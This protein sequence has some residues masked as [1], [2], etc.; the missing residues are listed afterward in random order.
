MTYQD[1]NDLFNLMQQVLENELTEAV[2]AVSK[3]EEPALESP[4][5]LICSVSCHSQTVKVDDTPLT[6][7]PPVAKAGESIEKTF[8]QEIIEIAA[9]VLKIPLDK[10]DSKENMA[11]YGVD[12]IIVTEIMRRIS[13]IVDLPIAPTL[14]FE[15]RHLEELAEILWKRYQKRIVERY[16]DNTPVPESQTTPVAETAI[17][18]D[19]EV[20]E[21]LKKYQHLNNNTPVTPEHPEQQTPFLVQAETS[22]SSD[23]EP[24]A[25]IAMEGM[26]AESSNLEEFAKHLRHGDD[27]IREIP[28]SRW[29]W[30]KVY[31]DPQQ[32]E[33]TR[34][35]FGGFIPEIDKFDPLFFG[36][37]PKEA[38]L[39]DPQHRLFIQ[40][41]WKLIESAGY[42][43]RSFSDK[44]IGL[45]LGINLQDY[46]HL[47]DRA[48]GMEA[49]HLTSLGHMFC[50]NRLSFLLN[51]H[52]PSQV[53]DTACSSSLVALH[54][55][56]LSIQHEGCEMA[57]AGGANLMISPDMHIMYSKVGMICEDGRCKTFSKQANGYVR[58]DGIGAVL[59]K[60]LSQAEADGDTILA[61]I[62]G[63]AE[64]HGGLSTSLTAPNP[65]AQAKLIVEAQQ[66]ANIDPRT[67]SYIECHGTGTSLGD[68]IEINGLK[69]AFAERFEQTAQQITPASCALGSVK[70]NIGHAETAAG[71]AGV[72]KVLLSLQDQYL[73]PTLHCAEVNPLIELNDSPFYLLQ[74]GRVWQRPIVDGKEY[75]RRAGISSFGAGGS[76]AHVVIEEYQAPARPDIPHNSPML[77]VLSAKNEARLQEIVKNLY[78]FLNEDK[79]ADLA[80]ADIAYT[81]QLGREAMEE[82]L[83]FFV[84]SKVELFTKLDALING[85]T[86]TDV[87]RGNSKQ[88]KDSRSALEQQA[89]QIEVTNH[90]L[91][92]LASLWAK[93]A[94]FDWQA[95]WTEQKPQRVKLP[96]YPFA[97]QRY[98]I[99]E[100][101][102]SRHIKTIVAQQTA[103]LHPLL[104]QNTSLLSE[105]R[106]TSNFTGNEFFL[107]DHV[108]VGNKMLPGVAYLEMAV[109]AVQQSMAIDR[110]NSSVIQL[111]NVVW[112]RPYIFDEHAKPLHIGLYPQSDTQINYSIYSCAEDEEKL[113]HSQGLIVL[114]QAINPTS[115]NLTALQQRLHRHLDGSAC[116][117][118]F[119]ALAMDYGAGHQGL[120]S[121]YF[122]TDDNTQPQVLAKLS[123]PASVADT[124]NQYTAHPSLLDSALQACVGLLF[125]TEVSAERSAKASLPFALDNLQLLAPCQTTMWAWIRYAEGGNN[126]KVQKLNIE[127]CDAQ[128]QVCVRLQGFSSRVVD[129]TSS[130]DT[131]Q[132]T[133]LLLSQPL[134]QV[135]DLHQSQ[136]PATFVKHWV[137]LCNLPSINSTQITEQLHNSHCQHLQI[138]ADNIA[139][140]YQTIVLT[141]FDAIQNLLKNKLQGNV[142]IQVVIANQDEARLVAGL[143]GLFK[144]VQREHATIFGQVIS[145]EAN[146]NTQSLLNK[147]H[148]NSLALDDRSIRYRAGQREIVI[149]Q[150]VP[151]T[152]E[153]YPVWKNNGVY[154]ITG[155]T[156]G[157]GRLFVEEIVKNTQDAVIIL[158]GRSS[159]TLQQQTQLEQLQ[160][161]GARIEYRRVD[162][163]VAEQ[164]DSLIATIVQNF[165]HLDGILHTAGVLQDNFIINKTAAEFAT[166]F[167]PKVAGTLHLDKAT[168]HLDMDFFVLFSSIAGGLGSAGQSDYAAANA[169]MD[170]FADYR[171]AQVRAKQRHGHTV[172]ILWSLWQDGGM[173]MDAASQASMTANIGL[174]PLQTTTAMHAFYQILMQGLS[175]VLVLEGQVARIKTQLLQRSERKTP[176]NTTTVAR[177]DNDALTRKIEQVLLQ[178]VVDLM[179]F[180]LADVDVSSELSEYGF[181]SISFTEFA[182]KLNK[183]LGLQLTPTSFFEYPTIAEF[184]QYLASNF[185]AELSVLLGLTATTAV[186]QTQET[187]QEDQPISFTAT[188]NNRFISPAV[189]TNV[190]TAATTQTQTISDEPIAIVGMSGCFPMAEDLQAFWQNLQAGKDCITEI[191]KDRWNWQALYGDPNK[192]RDKTNIKW[193]GFIDGVAEFDAQFFGISPREAEL[194][195]PQQRLLMQYVWAAIED[196]GYAPL[197]LSGS[198]TGLFI[199]TASSGYGEL[200]AKH[201]I[202]IDSYSATGTVGS[203]GPNR[204]SYFLNIHGPSEPIETACSSSLVAIHKA[205]LAIKHGDCEQAIVGG[206]NLIL[207]PETHISFNKAGMLCEDGRC[208]TFAKQANGYV[209]GEGVGMLFLKKLSDAE[210]AGDSIYAV[211]RGSSQNHGGRANSLTA[212]NPKAQA[213]C[214]ITAYKRA[215]IDP[216]TVSY[217][218]A[219]GTGTEL[220]DPIEINAL[221]NAFKDL[222]QA[223]GSSEVTQAHCGLSSVKTHIGHLEL[224]AGVAGVIRVILQMK[225]QTLVKGLH[226]AEVNPY[227]QLQDSPFYLV[228][229]NRP[230]LPLT[231][232]Q[233]H[234]VPRRAGVSSF[235]FGG[236]NAHVVLEEY[237][238]KQPATPT[239]N[240]EHIIVLSAKTPEGLHEIAVRL[241]AFIQMQTENTATQSA[242]TDAK[243][244]LPQSAALLGEL[245]QQWIAE[246]LA[247][248]VQDIGL[249]DDLL[250]CGLDTVQKSQLFSRLQQ[251]YAIEI[252]AQHF[253][254]Y[255]SI[256]EMIAGL[257]TPAQTAQTSTLNL[258]DL[259]YT[260][261]VGR[262][263]MEERLGFVVNSLAELTEKLTAFVHNNRAT[264]IYLGN[265]RDHK[266]I[267]ASF[268]SDDDFQDV[269]GKWI[270]R[271]KFT[272]LLD[273]WVKGLV[274]DWQKLY[275]VNAAYA[276]RPRRISLP[277]Y[278]FAKERYWIE[279]PLN[280]VTPIVSVP[281]SQP[282]PVVLA[283]P[284]VENVVTQDIPL[285]VK[286]RQF[287][288]DLLAS[289]LKLPAQRIK[290]N[291]ALETYGIDSMMVIELTNKLE[292]TFGSLSKTLFFEY[293]TLNELAD[294]F[295]QAHREQLENLFQTTSIAPVSAPLPLNNVVIEAKPEPEPVPTSTTVTQNAPLNIAIV[296]LS[297]RY[298]QADNLAQYWQ[299]LSEGKDCITEI[300]KER[301]DWQAYYSE[302]RREQ[303]KHFSKWGGFIRDVD[304][305][306][307]LFF[308]IS[309]REAET[310]DPQERL[311]LEHVW[312][313]LE[314]A[315]Y[316][317]EALQHLPNRTEQ[318]LAAQI[319]V[320]VGVMYSEYQLFAAQASLLGET[321]VASGSYA[322]IANRVSYLLNL[323]GPSMTLDTMCSSSLTA[324][325]LAC[326]DLRQGRT[327]M[328]FAGGVNVSVHPNK[329][330]MLSLGQFISTRGHC[331]SFGEGGDGYIPGEGVG[332]AVLKRLE[333]A[334]RDG[335]HIYGVIKGSA[336]NHGGKTNG[337]SVPNPKAQQ[338]VIS[339]ALKQAQVDPRTISYIEAHGTGTKLGDPIEITGLTKAFQKYT[340]DKQYCWLG[341]A[342]SNIGHCESA[343]GIAGVTKVLL[344]MQYEKI[345][346]SLHSQVLN[347]F[348][349]FN[350]TP[351]IVNQEL[352]PWQRPEHNGKTLPRI[353]GISSFGAGG[354]NAH[355]IIEEYSKPHSALTNSITNQPYA[356]LLSAKT[357]DQLLGLVRQLI[358]YTQGQISDNALINIAYTLQ[359]GRQ[360]MN[361]RLG[362]IVTSV[363]ELREKL[364]QFLQK[365]FV[366]NPDAGVYYARIK[367]DSEEPHI[368]HLDELLTQRQ[369][370]ELLSYWLQDVAIDWRKLYVNTALPQRISL[371]T[372]PFAKE[373]YWL[374]VQ[375]NTTPKADDFFLH[376]LIHKNSS[377]ADT[378]RFSTRFTAQEFFLR[379]HK[380]QGHAI[381]PAVAYL[382][383]ARAAVQH[384][385]HLQLPCR[386]KNI[387]WARPLAVDEPK[388]VHIS[389]TETAHQSLSYQI[390]GEDNGQVV[391]SQGSI[392]TQPLDVTQLANLN[393]SVLQAR[394]NQCLLTAEQC[395]T[396]FS[397]MGLDYGI[398][399]RALVAVYG[400]TT[401]NH[402]ELLAQL[403]MPAEVRAFSDLILHPSMLDSALQ[404]AIGFSL[405]SSAT[406][407]ALPFALDSVEVYQP[408]T[409]KMW[410]WLR[411]SDNKRQKLAIDLCDDQGVLC[412]RLIG[413][414]LRLLN[415]TESPDKTIDSLSLAPV[416]QASPAVS[417]TTPNY[418]AHYV[419]FCGTETNMALPS[420]ICSRL[421]STATELAQRFQD[422]ALTL[423]D[424]IKQVLSQKHTGQVLFQV[425]INPETADLP[426]LL[427]A[428]LAGLLKTARQENPQF[429]TQL[430]LLDAPIAQ[431]A[432]ATCLQENAQCPNDVLISYQAQQRQIAVWQSL[433]L[434]NSVQIPW[435]EHGVYLIT[436]G[437]GGLGF[438]FAQEIAQQCQQVTL[439]LTGRSSINAEIQHKLSALTALN[440]TKA[441]YHAIDV[442]NQTAVFGLMQD[443]TKEYGGLNAI[444]HC[445]GVTRDGFILKKT[446]TDWQQVFA[447]KV[448]GL[449][450]LDL[451][452]RSQ[453]LDFFIL[454][455]SVAGA[456]GNV[457][458]AD[459]ATA[460]AF[461]D[462]YAVYRNDL[463][464][465]VLSTDTRPKGLTLSINWPLWQDGGMDIAPEL[466]T[467]MR[468]SVG[469]I[470]LTTATALRHFYQSL[471]AGLSQV[472][473]VE[474]EVERLK[475]KLLTQTAESEPQAETS[476][477]THQE[478]LRDKLD[479]Y[480]KGL[481]SE[482][483]KI[484]LHRI[485]TGVALEKYGMDSVSVMTLTNELEQLF[486]SLPKTLLFEYS[487]IDA[488]SRYFLT[489]HADKLP[490]AWR[491][492]SIEP[493]T[494][495]PVVQADTV[496]Q[497][498]I[499]NTDIAIIGLAGRY[500]QAET[501]AEFWQN[502][503]E[504]K[505]NIRE[506]PASRWQYRDYFSEDK[507]Q[508]GKS[509]CKWG[510]FLD[511]VDE[512]DPLFFNIS[513][514]EAKIMDPME[515]LFLETVW[516]LL[517]SA[518]YLGDSLAKYA[519]DVA[520]YVGAM[521][522]QYQQ[523]AEHDRIAP[524]SSF[525]AIANRVS[526]F[527]N[528]QGASVAID[529]M[530]SSAMVALHLACDSLL[531]QECKLAIVGGVNLSLHPSKYIGLSSAQLLGSHANSTS[532][533]EGDGYIPA[534]GVGAVLLKPLASAIQDNDTILAVI[535]STAINHNGQA[536][537]YAVPNPNAQGQLMTDNF[538]KANIDPRSISY[539]EAAANG[540]LLGD[541]IE[542]KALHNVFN[543]TNTAQN[544]CALGSVKA[545][546]GHAEAASGMAQLS[547]VVLQLQHQQIVPLIKAEPLNPRLDFSHSPF[548]LPRQV[549]TWQ[550][551]VVTLEDGSTR[552]LPRRAVLNS[553]G[554]GGTNVHV[555]IEEYTAP[556]LPQSETAPPYLILL[557]AKNV[558]QLRTVIQRLISF[559]QNHA[560]LSLANLAYT[561]QC[562]R[563]ALDCRLA[564]VVENKTQLLSQLQSAQRF[565]TFSNTDTLFFADIHQDHS[566]I[567]QSVKGTAGQ[568]LLQQ[569]LA[570]KNLA[571]LGFY[572]VHGVTID[573]QTLHHGSAVQRIVLPTYPFVKQRY[574]LN[575]TS[576]T[577]EN[578]VFNSQLSLKDNM[579][580][581]L[582]S[583]VANALNI[584]TSSI[585][586][587][588]D[589]R[590]YGMNSL[591]GMNL[592]RGFAEQ[593]AVATSARDL[594]NH[595]SIAQ[596][597]EYFAALNPE[598]VSDL[599]VSTTTNVESV[600]IPL[601]EGQKGL[602]LLHKFAPEMSAYN[603]PIA[604]ESNT[605]LNLQALKQACTWLMTQHSLLRAVIDE[606]N[607]NVPYQ[608]ILPD[609]SLSLT[610][611]L[612]EHLNETELFNAVKQQSKAVFQ[613]NSG[614]LFRVDVFYR[615]NQ[616]AIVLLTVHHLIFDGRSA[617]L[618]L[619]QL[620]SLYASYSQQKTPRIT[621]PQASYHDF[622]TWEHAL[623][624]STTGQQHE[625]YWQTQLAGELPVCLFP[626]DYARPTQQS[627]TGRRYEIT[628]NATLSAQLKTLAYKQAVQLSSV[629]L[630]AFNVLFYRYTGQTDILMGMP[631]QGRPEA[632]FDDVIG[633]FINVIVIR[634]QLSAEQTFAELLNTVQFTVADGLDHAAYPLPRLI[635]LLKIARDPAVAPL[636]QM[637]YAYQN[638]ATT[639]AESSSEQDWQLLTDI[640]QEGAD[641]FALEV[642]ENNDRFVIS[643]DYNTD[644]FAETTIQRLMQHYLALLQAVSDAPDLAISH[645]D[646]LPSSERTQ[647]L[648]HWSG[649]QQ[650]ITHNIACI[651]DL[652]IKQA[653]KTPEQIALIL[654]K[655]QLSYR[656]LDQLSNQLAHALQKQGIVSGDLVGV[657]MKPSLATVVS[658]LAIFKLGAVYVP[659][660]VQL[661]K[662]RRQYIIEDS[663]IK[664]L[665]T[666]KALPEKQL[667]CQQWVI[668]KQ[669]QNLAGYKTR[670]KSH[671]QAEQLAYIIYTSGST[672]KPKG[673][674]ITH[675]AIAGH[676]QTMQNIYQLTEKDRVLQFASFAVD[677]S[678]EQL[679]PSLISGATVVLR[680]KALWSVQ[681]F[682]QHLFNYQLSII[683]IPPAYL[684]EW[685]L[686]LTK[687]TDIA[688]PHRLR[689][690]ITGGDV[691]TTH[692]V[693]LWRNSAMR[694][695]AL[696]NAY[697]PTETTIT[698]TLLNLAT[699]NTTSQNISIGRPLPNECVYILD[700]LGQAVPTGVL[701]ELHIG[702]AGLA[703][704]YLHRLDLTQ[705]KFIASPFDTKSKLYKTGDLA[706]W[707][708]DGTIEFL[709]RVDY[710]VKVR[711]FRIECGEIENV[712]LT[713]T[714]VKNALVL[715][716]TEQNNTQLRAYLVP[717]HNKD[718]DLQVLKHTLQQTLPSYMLPSAFVI[719]DKIPLTAT[720]KVD[721]QFLLNQAVDSV[722]NAH[723]VAPMTD[724]EQQ[725]A[726]IWQQLLNVPRI[727][728]FDNFFDL[729]GHSLLAVRL[730]AEITHHF[731]KELALSDLFKNPTIAGLAD[732]LTQK[733][734]DDSPLVVLQSQ[735]QKA[736]LFLIHA[737]T[738]QVLC[739][740]ELVNA[741]GDLQPCYGLEAKPIQ[742]HHIES[743]AANYITHIKRVQTSGAYYLAGWS[744]G[745]VIAYEMAR[746]LKNAGE[747]VALLALID[748]Y[749][750][751][752]L[753]AI[754]QDALEQY[755]QDNLLFMQFAQTLGLA[756]NTSNS[757]FD[758]QARLTELGQQLGDT[759]DT[760]LNKLNHLFTVY[761]THNEAMNQYQPQTYTGRVTLFT[762]HKQFE[763]NHQGIDNWSTL[764]GGNIQII[765]IT[766]DHYSL[767]QNENVQVLAT[768]LKKHLP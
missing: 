657:C 559:I 83:A 753:H 172:S 417:T 350:A 496:K 757:D 321:R 521:Y 124:F 604:I 451:A 541:A 30:Q 503:V 384:S 184:A 530:C 109:T 54:R 562:G 728:I 630:A 6:T 120:N 393:L 667:N 737:A 476:P 402:H 209:R 490:K 71:I 55:A 222:Y 126:S 277:T 299:N 554:A 707:L 568:T 698:S 435:R 627:F 162:V 247:V 741:L 705:E 531:K 181:D 175:H 186:E 742:Q 622:V 244:R 752:Q 310:M 498:V 64:N 464:T 7:K 234:A 747:N 607:N 526:Y 644:L 766:G 72:I 481:L 590:A 397:A 149:W 166:V 304:K 519:K 602:W 546:M 388:T 103:V 332:V 499:N 572:W 91:P 456:M 489:H 69:M 87:Y 678:L 571:Q 423:F 308:N 70:S 675:G 104:Q 655:Q 680:D 76:N 706:R 447:P 272:R 311:F 624:N 427:Y 176:S 117:A 291:E 688:I 259:A 514:E 232:Q 220:G 187:V 27:C 609:C 756:N 749:T 689:L 111:K 262:S 228:Q 56:I 194:M 535:K 266:A 645:Y 440:N 382:E 288:I 81:L 185:N 356:I 85:R 245:L 566:A 665:L 279:R 709:G 735:G 3:Q 466:K 378:Q 342:K 290:A 38:E 248:N 529:T 414:S 534:E 82:R 614:A 196:A 387:V 35:K 712:L 121:L 198:K 619:Q 608:F 1:E 714:N 673:V 390:Y 660:D 537:G 525:S 593:F 631:T 725:L 379:D 611:H 216:R 206:L 183:Q 136:P 469:L 20:A 763:T 508:I 724:T 373:R 359:V 511:G 242:H 224:A 625:H 719:L 21:W 267:L 723:Y 131:Q 643:M 213:D 634:S 18:L 603:V 143:A 460:N 79:H 202:A 115:V 409:V 210:Q 565:A 240:T 739:Y 357:K 403:E 167:A 377:T 450:N 368:A 353:A 415:R 129:N 360:A 132:S 718:I 326:L 105:Q 179:K 410:A 271:K 376:P 4:S 416:W 600:Q 155:G 219:H 639:R 685:L 671:V 98:W 113:V 555:I 239:S 487:N 458:Q 691:L 429:T 406:N 394:F 36:M 408:C 100:S 189:Q 434:N 679:L 163:S 177:V 486:G 653:K 208:K 142:L 658:L 211:I 543:A 585:H 483:L 169:F 270:E 327:D 67:I 670:F 307:P 398:G 463:V 436:G 141:V 468:N 51:I 341:S 522:Q 445:A 264:D 505:D 363:A 441:V 736:P 170:A 633:Y 497:P 746:Q 404:A 548:Y 278:P 626:T 249:E 557:S 616:T 60:K 80:L 716:K 449:V 16:V 258:T 325:H 405:A 455:S 78:Q 677:A 539:V 615:A 708:A 281:V 501:L 92:I 556:A 340:V 524:P 587:Q 255:H 610:E 528:L 420:V 246:L 662:A 236:V 648:Q 358:A 250:D 252:S 638:F 411:Y 523:C 734:T 28:A 659:I 145:I 34:V 47:I 605:A 331:E 11:R 578:W 412:V 66:R 275:G 188:T 375:L 509:Y 199:G 721:R 682:Q 45:F 580:H 413:L 629:F 422:Y 694:H 642:Y 41:V 134:W 192:E 484:P 48:G 8:S 386:L 552:T 88:S 96:S 668:D 744:L 346:P 407:A 527:F 148:D 433:K 439:I 545:N 293:Q 731:H 328:A 396:Q 329:Y 173:Q 50:P 491:T 767:L 337:Y 684:H 702:G 661:P 157:L 762:S 654:G 106:F 15:A 717:E 362:L 257:S 759:S 502:L 564:F 217:I 282:A 174:V 230:W 651:P 513:P 371:P 146:D 112:A 582:I 159:F 507:Q 59:L 664:L 273:L 628:L 153:T 330:T 263:V 354:S 632:R 704:G 442:S 751:A 289:T 459:Y 285:P 367:A 583:Y 12:S 598:S 576:N 86:V 17:D 298:P 549:Q 438:L 215:N 620:V 280:T 65:K 10:I 61:V 504:G 108:M 518:G 389:L 650:H 683:D 118:Q 381:L 366:S 316:S 761:K 591:V 374:D 284:V 276:V 606:D 315:G 233:G 467:L 500:P 253:L 575:D 26:F 296:G 49:L 649:V 391:Y 77:I 758:L 656:E 681:E 123:L 640:R 690:I 133:A 130:H 618:L 317:P 180:D 324:L 494:A 544:F 636:F 726:D 641:D 579:Q 160:R 715:A 268:T 760:T 336:L 574:W 261:Q 318:D 39:M 74:H 301:W 204:M 13:D 674:M 493:V 235:G 200:I 474:G 322:S 352:R 203:V 738:G 62:R 205:I 370:A 151:E 25:I 765:D 335:D 300:P 437:A 68:P 424:N 516:N 110:A 303:G 40:C 517:E 345:A 201:Q 430:I 5:T 732:C 241:L 294:Y 58:G 768:L 697:G 119:H 588:K 313:A 29:D 53:I 127:L 37:S 431:S 218:E 22:V 295:L 306:D 551:P 700:A 482:L 676:C 666:K 125:G 190:V 333:D 473:I 432:I 547:K 692:T 283:S 122:G 446:V 711:G 23:Y 243:A 395:Y 265:V 558:E 470:P 599:T 73:Y 323:H 764:S 227:I 383:M 479:D 472:L 550:Q 164:V 532:F 138:T 94:S 586:V 401:A 570:E 297:G 686:A 589:L 696:L 663:Q 338:S 150:D 107:A 506:I 207:V 237:T 223:T 750:P 221:K 292:K 488:L 612:C 418:A 97:K 226:C 621:A 457:G 596:L 720:G 471:N 425:L 355:L 687:Q 748:S 195:D 754:E 168:R 89:S 584:P 2:L 302:N 443:I 597:A 448:T 344:Q 462:S 635:K 161:N 399:H 14:F 197:S 561:L 139:Q 372:Y 567:R 116:Y 43:P 128:G 577:Q 540:S 520:V 727:S 52:G 152:R 364:Q 722:D 729:G 703:V 385:Q 515:R 592:L 617:W 193:G 137:F 461:M 730:M 102:G 613:L 351:F 32:G 182:N 672:G 305:F 44:K 63:S 238:N 573:W 347:P 57:I 191:P 454:F 260:L 542:L 743:I 84:Q 740:R 478:A 343:A 452:S 733:Q 361:E 400:E 475:A 286:T 669:W 421:H 426:I 380:V 319:G 31:G 492:E 512:F 695:I 320:Y 339:L 334:E 701:G 536:N 156:G 465:G 90:N 312:L 563:V 495:T 101:I 42:A 269:I 231:D 114:H 24:I 480:L 594:L 428:G 229:H 369:Y 19:D 560:D 287:L 251:Q 453:N 135:A 755:G 171:N 165:G 699:V 710:Q 538:A 477:S 274:I 349:D 745:G 581:Y 93:G 214:L 314:D 652:F 158:T 553:F 348:I 99:P 392:D 623:L 46:A 601:S 140:N 365:P 533:A 419:V 225:H 693:E 595:P 637:S 75:P 178:A 485:E 510:S 147:L 444:L 646:F 254:K 212:P 95:L 647:I 309:P 713:D 9:G 33:F 154:L 569:L 256:A 144:S